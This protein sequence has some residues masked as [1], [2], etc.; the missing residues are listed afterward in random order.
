MIYTQKIIEK[1]YNPESE[2]YKNLMI[3]NE[4]V[5][6]K[7]LSIAKNL[8]EKKGAEI[9]LAFLKEAVAL[10]DIAV[11]L[12]NA[13][14]LHCF[15]EEKYIKHGILGREILEKENLPKHA[16]VCERHVGVGITKEGIIEENL[17]LP[18][19]DMLPETIEEKIVCIADN[20]FS[21][22]GEYMTKEKPLSLIKKLYENISPEHVERLEKLLEE[23]GVK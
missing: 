18:A 13:P 2:I 12:T 10:H 5:T 15:G 4:A 21:K 8:Q 22:D 23:L 7:A 6:K 9:D 3:H 1:Y 19:R 17:P 16:L 14:N 20:F 11:F